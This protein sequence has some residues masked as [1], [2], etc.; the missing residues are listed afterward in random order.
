MS[1]G[2]DGVSSQALMRA[3]GFTVLCENLQLN[4]I[5][6]TAA[7]IFTEVLIQTEA[8]GSQFVSFFRKIC[9]SG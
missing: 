2:N 8:V 6:D 3:D 9:V 4:V 1:S 7:L 5:W